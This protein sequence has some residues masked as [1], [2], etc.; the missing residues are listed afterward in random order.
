[1][2][3]SVTVSAKRDEA[4]MFDVSFRLLPNNTA[5][6][7]RIVD[8]TLADGNKLSSPNSPAVSESF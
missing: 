7:G 2:W 5:S 6:Y 4:T 8:R 3:K 1:M